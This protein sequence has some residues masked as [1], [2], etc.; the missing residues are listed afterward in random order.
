MLTKR[1]SI[2][3]H[4]NHNM[5]SSRWPGPDP[6]FHSRLGTYYYLAW[7]VQEEIDRDRRREGTAVIYA[8]VRYHFHPFNY[9]VEI[10]ILENLNGH[11][12]ELCS[13]H[14]T[15][16]SASRAES[17]LDWMD[18]CVECRQNAIRKVTQGIFETESNWGTEN[19]RKRF[20][21]D[22]TDERAGG[23]SMCVHVAVP[24]GPI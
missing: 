11:K 18:W 2:H 8:N 13:A 20:W 1:T 15:R 14:E 10:N 4:H 19:R 22:I 3:R 17:M 5:S 6:A 7:S 12:Q 21:S 24:G 23:Q 16:P 9:H